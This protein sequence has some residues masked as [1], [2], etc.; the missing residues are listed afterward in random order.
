MDLA[1]PVYVNFPQSIPFS[2]N[3]SEVYFYTTNHGQS[4]KAT[5]PRYL[6]P[7]L[8]WSA[9]TSEHAPCRC[10][11]NSWI[12]AHP[13]ESL[14]T[15]P[16]FRPTFT[17]PCECTSVT[18]SRLRCSS[19]LLYHRTRGIQAI[20]IILTSHKIS[21][22]YNRYLPSSMPTPTYLSRSEIVFTLTSVA[23]T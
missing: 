1:E 13:S 19:Y 3:S 4:G 9:S 15:K 6:P 21:Y 18:S 23:P 10:V 7:L 5:F 16:S 22:T 12:G 11:I 17:A 14:A 2:A 8:L 20:K